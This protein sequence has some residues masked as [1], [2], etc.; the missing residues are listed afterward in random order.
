MQDQVILYV[1]DDPL[2]REA[3]T[4]VLTRVMKIPTVYVFE[5]STDF[6]KRINALEK[7]PDIFLL[8]IHMSPITGFEML[9]LL[10]NELQFTEERV[11]ALTAS[12]M[13]EEV[14]LLKESGFN[15]VIG[16]PINVATFPAILKRV[17]D[18]ESVWHITE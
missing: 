14:N 16:K 8:D 7:R 1:E 13:N 10:R 12:V 15:G 9:K 11:I 18:G 6:V 2:S 4:I 5:D 3:L 17:A